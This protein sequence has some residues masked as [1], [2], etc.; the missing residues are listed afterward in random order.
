MKN[1]LLAAVLGII[2][3][4]GL[5]VLSSSW[6]T[7]NSTER[8]VMTTL[9]VM[10]NEP[11]K[12]GLGMKTPL[13]STVTKVNIQQCT[14]ELQASCF[15]SDLQAIDIKVKVLYRIPESSV[16]PIIRDYAGSPFQSLIT[17]RVQEA[18]KEVTALRTA[19]DIVQSREAV[20]S[21]ALKGSREKVGSIIEIADIVIE[22]VA[23]SHELEAAI[24]AKM[25]QQ[26]EA[27]KA[28]FKKQQAQTEADTAIISAKA[29]AESIRIQGE[30]L[31]NNPALV[32][33]KMVEKWD[34]HSPQIVG[35]GV[36]PML[37]LPAPSK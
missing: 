25:V 29:Q 37:P 21:A 27:E 36:N 12:P 30:A 24:E 10:S 6:Y 9:G 14:D 11:L 23:L 4:F 3:L 18:I 34:G 20:K 28:V 31:Q 26:Q 15:S 8:G 5:I 17:P 22:D 33:L 1:I 16:V 13:I 35:V 32:S 19:S 2:A 7:I